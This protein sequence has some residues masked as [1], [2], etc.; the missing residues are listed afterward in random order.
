MFAEKKRR[1]H[2]KKRNKKKAGS[3]VFINRGSGEMPHL[4]EGFLG[5]T[6]MKWNEMSTFQ[7]VAHVIGLVC[8]LAYGVAGICYFSGILPIPYKLPWVQVMVSVGWLCLGV[9]NWERYRSSAVSYFI[10]ALL[11]FITALLGWFVK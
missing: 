9:T 11:A 7:R 2:P 1:I 5:G 3:P 10:T 4:G 6:A 8:A